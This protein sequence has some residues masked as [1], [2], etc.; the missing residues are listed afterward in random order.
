MHYGFGATVGALYG[1]TAELL[2]AVKCA[3]GLPFGAAL[4]V[5]ADE[6]AVPRLG[7]SKSFNAYPLSAHAQALASHFVYSMTAELVRRAVRRVL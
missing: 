1:G 7:L 2:P 5:G 4:F 6:I 3:V